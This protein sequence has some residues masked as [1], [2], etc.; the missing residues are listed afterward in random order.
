[1]TSNVLTVGGN[2]DITMTFA[3]PASTAVG[4]TS[5]THR[6]DAPV[7][8]VFDVASALI[9]PYVL[10]QAPGAVGF[11]GITSA[12]GIGSVRWLADRGGIKDT[13]IDKVYVGASAVPEPATYGLML[14]GIAPVGISARRGA[15]RT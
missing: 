15:A 9:G 1:V 3:G 12:V 6:F 4:F 7:V 14:G 10:T 11:V 2:E 5:L 8:T 13:A